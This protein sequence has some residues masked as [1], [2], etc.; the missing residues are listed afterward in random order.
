MAVIVSR[1]EIDEEVLQNVD[2][3]G[4]KTEFQSLHNWE[5]LA[6]GQNAILA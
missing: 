6:A 3:S 1:H 2:L 5:R 4:S